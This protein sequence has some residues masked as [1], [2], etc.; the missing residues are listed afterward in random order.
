[1]ILV[2]D[3]VLLKLLLNPKINVNNFQIM[4][5]PDMKFSIIAKVENQAKRKGVISKYN[6]CLCS[7]K[8]QHLQPKIDKQKWVVMECN[9]KLLTKI[10]PI[11]SFHHS[12][13][14]SKD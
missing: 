11:I 12:L 5:L 13:K 8:S 9:V 14:Q 7:S 3:L 6:K 10:M 2:K 4:T 1:M